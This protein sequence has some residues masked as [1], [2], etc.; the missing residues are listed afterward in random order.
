MNVDEQE[1][2]Y[3]LD[4][5]E[6]EFLDL[7]PD[8]TIWPFERASDLLAEVLRVYRRTDSFDPGFIDD[9]NVRDAAARLKESNLILVRD[10]LETMEP[11]VAEAFTEE[12]ADA[13]ST[14][15]LQQD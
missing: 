13:L 15:Q 12:A 10:L 11:D 9:G 14:L 1:R 6:A 8:D 3:T 2:I 4:A 5:D 7:S